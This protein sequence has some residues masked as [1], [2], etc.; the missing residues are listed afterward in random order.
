MDFYLEM[1][2]CAFMNIDLSEKQI[3]TAESRQFWRTERMCISTACVKATSIQ[4]EISGKLSVK[5]KS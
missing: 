3:T 2:I 4:K 1:V 5:P